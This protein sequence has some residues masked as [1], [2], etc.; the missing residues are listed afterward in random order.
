MIAAPTLETDRLR[1]RGPGAQD[2]EGWV[3]FMASPRSS[4]AGGPQT[5]AEAWR[6]FG[7]MIGHWVLRGYGSFAMTLRTDDAA[8]GL[9]GPYFPEGRPEREIGWTL[10]R[11]EAEGHGYAAEAARAALAHAFGPLGW[12][13]AVSYIEPENARSIVLAERLG[14][15]RDDAAAT[16][17][18]KPCLVYRH[19]APEALR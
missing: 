3:A 2:F 8:L 19:P 13:T 4:M 16:P 17:D 6:S 18:G 14:A 9:V 15:A 7:H 1:L 12:D 5:R 10:W 11:P